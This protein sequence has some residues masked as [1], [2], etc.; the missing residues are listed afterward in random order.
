MVKACKAF[1]VNATGFE[2]DLL[3]LVL[4]MEQRRQKQVQKLELNQKESGSLKKKQR[5]RGEEKIN[6]WD[7][8]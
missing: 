5:R 4:R 3:D 6:L 1:G 2:H 8:L 7:Q